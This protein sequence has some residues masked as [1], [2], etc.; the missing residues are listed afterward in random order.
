MTENDGLA[1]GQTDKA[2]SQRGNWS[3]LTKVRRKRR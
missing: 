3:M 2:R 1:L